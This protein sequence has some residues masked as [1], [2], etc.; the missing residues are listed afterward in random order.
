MTSI[1]FLS[2][3]VQADP[4]YSNISQVQHHLLLLRTCHAG[5]VRFRAHL[6]ARLLRTRP[7]AS[8]IAPRRPSWDA[9]EDADFFYNSVYTIHVKMLV[10]MCRCADVPMCR[11]ADVP[12]LR[13][14]SRGLCNRPVEWHPHTKKRSTAGSVFLSSLVTSA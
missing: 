10:P 6:L 12:M 11:C 7:A 3:V 13:H 14:N 2:I 5:Q 9:K 4:R 1:A 8:A